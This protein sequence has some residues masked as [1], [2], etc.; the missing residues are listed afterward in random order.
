MAIYTYIGNGS[1]W[2]TPSAW[3]GNIVPTSSDTA[4]VNTAGSASDGIIPINTNVVVGTLILGVPSAGAYV[5]LRISY[6]C[7]LTVTGLLTTD[8]GSGT[9]QAAYNKRPVI[10]GPINSGYGINGSFTASLTV[11]AVSDTI[12][13]PGYINNIDFCGIAVYGNAAPLRG[14]TGAM[15]GDLKGNS[16]IIFPPARSIYWSGTGSIQGCYTGR[17]LTGT[18]TNCLPQDT[19]IIDNTT[20]AS[21][22]TLTYTNPRGNF[23]TETIGGLD[24]SL[25]TLP[26]TITSPNQG[27]LYLYG[28]LKLSSAV[29]IGANT[30][31]FS[32]VGRNTQTL[33]SA[34]KNFGSFSVSSPG[35]TVNLGDALNI[36]SSVSVYGGTFNTNNYNITASSFGTN[37]TTAL[38]SPI[39]NFGSSTINLSSSS[40]ISISGSI[41]LNAG[42][43]TVN[44][45]STGAIS[46]DFS[47]STWWNVNF[48]NTRTSLSL[49]GTPT[50]NN[51][52]FAQ[53]SLM[54]TITLYSNI[55]VTGT[56]TVTSVSAVTRT[57]F[58]SSTYG[59]RR[60]ITAAAV[61]LSDCDF[62]DITA[63]GTATWSGTRLG[64]CKGNSGITFTTPK[65]VYWNLL[66]ASLLWSATAWC[67]STDGGTTLS[68]PAVN[69]FPLAQDTA[70]FKE[71]GVD[72]GATIIYSTAWNLGSIDLSARSSILY[73]SFTV[74][75]NIYGDWTGYSILTFASAC[76]I[77][78]RGRNTQT[79]TTNGMTMSSMVIN[80]PGGIVQLGGYGYGSSVTGDAI[81]LVEGTFDSRTTY[82]ELYGGF[83][84]N[85]TNTRTLNMGSGNWTFRGIAP[86]YVATTNLTYNKGTSVI[87]LWNTDTSATT[88]FVG[89]D[90]SFNDIVIGGG[91]ATT[92][93]TFNFSGTSGYI[94]ALYASKNVAFTIAL[95][96]STPTYGKWLVTG[97]VGKVVTITGT[98]AI[99]LLER[100]YYSA[101]NYI[102]Y[103]NTTLATNSLVEFYVGPNSTGTST[104]ITKAA[105][106]SPSASR[107]L[108]WRGGTGTWNAS[109]TNWSLT[110]NG[111]GGQAPPT[112]I[113]D[114]I[115]DSTSNPT[116]YTVTIS[117]VTARCRT[118]SINGPVSGSVT[119][120]GT[121][122]LVVGDS[123]TLPGGTSKIIR[124]YTGT[125][126]LGN[127]YSD[128]I[129]TNSNISPN[130]VSFASP[131]VIYGNVNGTS[132]R[133]LQSALSTTST[134]TIYTGVLVTNGYGLTATS[135]IS[136]NYNPRGLTLNGS[137]VNLS[138]L[139]SALTLTNTNSLTF[140]AGTS[141]INLNLTQNASGGGFTVN[142]G[143]ISFYN[144]ML[145]S[146]ATAGIHNVILASDITISGTLSTSPITNDAIHR[147]CLLPSVSGTPRTVSVNSS[148]SLTD[149]DF[150]EITITGSAAP[151]TG[152][153]LGNYGGNSGITFTA[154][155][156]VYWNLS[157]TQ[158]WDATAWCT[159]TDGGTTLSAPDINNFPLA[160]DTAKFN[161][162]G[163]V[164]GTIS[165]PNS[166]SYAIGT[167]DCSNRTIAMTLYNNQSRFIYGSFILSSAVNWYS[168][169]SIYFA[170]R[171]SYTITSAG[172]PLTA[173]TIYISAI[174]G[175]Y[176]LGDAMSTIT[177][178]PMSVTNG[179]FTTNGYAITI[180]SFNSNA[181]TTRTINLGASTITCNN[182]FG[183]IWNTS[184]TTNLT[185]NAGT[186][187]IIF[188]DPTAQ[189]GYTRML[190]GGGLTYNKFT[191][192][193]TAA[194]NQIIEI[195]GNNTFNEITTTRTD[196]W[197][198]NFSSSTQTI[199]NWNITG[200]TGIVTVAGS[201]SLATL[202]LLNTVSNNIFSFYNHSL[203]NIKFV[204]SSP[205]IIS[206][207]NTITSHNNII[208]LTTNYLTTSKL[209]TSTGVL[210]NIGEF[211]EVTNN[212][213]AQGSILFNGSS[214]YLTLPTSSAFAYGTGDFTIEFWVYF[215][216]ISGYQQLIDTRPTGV[217]STVNYLA[218]TSIGGT[219]NYYTADNNP[220]ISGSIVV[221]A[222]QWYHIAITKLSGST[223]LF[224]N[225]VQSGS[226]YSDTTTYVSG[227]NRPIIGVDGNNP[228]TSFFNGYLSNLRIVKDTAVYTG[229]FTPP[230]Q[231]LTAIS[232]TSLLLNTR[233]SNDAFI[234][235]ST[236]ALTVTN[237][238]GSLSSPQHP[239]N[240]D[241]YYSYLFNGTTQ[242]LTVAHNTALSLTT[243]N[244][245]IEGWIRTN[246]FTNSPSIYY[247][248]ATRLIF[249]QIGIGITT[250]GRLALL[251]SNAAG[252]AWAIND[253][254][255]MP[256]ML[257]GTW[258]HFA[259]VRNGN[260]IQMYLDGTQYINSTAISSATT[261]RD[262]GS[263]V[264]IGAAAADGGGVSLP[265][266]GYISNF[267]VVKGT[268]VYTE[269]FTPPTS[270]LT[271]ITNTT[272]LTLQSNRIKDSNFTITPAVT[273]GPT[274]YSNT[275]P[276]STISYANTGLPV[277]KQ[278]STGILQTV[279]SFDEVS[280]NPTL[281]GSVLFNGTSQYM[282][283]PA[284]AVLNPGTGDFTIEAWI[285]LSAT[286]TNAS[287][288]RGNAN[289]IE[290]YIDGSNRLS[291]GYANNAQIC[292]DAVALSTGQWYHVAVAR[293]GT[294]LTLYKNGA[295]VATATNSTNY[296]TA[297]SNLIGYAGSSS[298]YFNGYISNL[299]MVKG[300]AVYT[301]AFTPPTQ[302]LTTT[303]PAGTNIAAITNQTSFL[304]RTLITDAS[305]IST[306]NLTITPVG[307]PTNSAANPFGTDIYGSMLFNGTTQYLTVPSNTV[308]NLTG[309]FT[310]EAWAYATTTTN[311][312][313]QLFNYGN[314][315]FML[316]H[317][318]TTWT[319][320]IGNGTS[321][322]FTLTGTASLNSWHH[323][324]ITRSGNIYTF[325]ID[326]VSALTA[327]NSNAPA[328]SGAALSIGR[329]QSAPNT[330]WFTGYISNFRI[331]KG[332]A[333]YTAA[334]TPPTAPLTAITNTSLLTCQSVLNQDNSTNVLA[335][336]LVLTN[337]GSTT[338]STNPFSRGYNSLSFDG[339]SQYLSF[340][341]NSSVQLSS[342]TWTIECWVNLKAFKPTI[343]ANGYIITSQTAGSNG[344]DFYLLGTTSAWNGIGFISRNG[345]TNTNSI[346]N[347]YSFA[348]NT[349]YHIAAVSA[350]NQITLYV[351]GVSV[352][353]NFFSGWT[354]TSTYAIGGGGVTPYEYY[355]PGYISNLRVVKGTAVYSSNFTPPK[356]P[357]T[358]ITNTS[359][360]ICQ[361]M[362]LQDNSINKFAITNNG[363]AVANQT[364]IPFQPSAI[365]PVVTSGT[366][367]R[368]QL[369]TGL[370]Q[371]YNQ[372]D[373]YTGIT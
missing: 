278:Y 266:D 362:V 118:L 250:A 152:T 200:N 336:K 83:N 299:R 349:W 231:P 108:Y 119:L 264:S 318:G 227:T 211:D 326:G 114:V 15:I 344:F 220:S 360:L 263:A 234:D 354:E 80:S 63:A 57:F 268:A 103:G 16:N 106:P 50:F 100:S 356:A 232:S 321:N 130:G 309:D 183:T 346:S 273:T 252:N 212:P 366:T 253:T 27:T 177:G 257:T 49:T 84:S 286:S 142:T 125:I 32:F 91:D 317:A 74:F 351:N 53:T 293:S 137:T 9:Y 165:I 367:L 342:S 172:I 365:D 176:T 327:T 64:D 11:N 170:G 181:T 249:A 13:G 275:L 78:F 4:I 282:T 182:Y 184:I 221:K 146:S 111:A 109:T 59:T 2:N 8:S 259:L 352:A 35:G 335:N 151:I 71:T 98:A 96:N 277:S 358:A 72:A 54:N 216:S 129:T 79:I 161:D 87:N 222:G 338:S 218:L 180:Y 345:V 207:D 88:T 300:L 33:T 224:I 245:T 141:T 159:S 95:G 135:L 307:T 154:P 308:L 126:I 36:T 256:V 206:K 228:T 198:L 25:R 226:T 297:T 134:I 166:T 233:Y 223:K 10:E 34:G 262:D 240:P 44:C 113:D 303:Q 323:F 270:P 285:Y 48:T 371:V 312:V 330:Q 291:V 122:T 58:I 219:I 14:P 370:I 62:R 46:A 138:G 289:G 47:T 31:I 279:G 239:F 147:I 271:A 26:I 22:A 215:N 202:I 328:T 355:L 40:P 339:T 30:F 6:G 164:T 186:S 149:I 97:S 123:M 280:L 105:V 334:F 329:S 187:N 1:S 324:A 315:I 67:T 167:L 136:S 283:V 229:A 92:G 124:T 276:F 357:L 43:S 76:T 284:N 160:Q 333:V 5:R 247:K 156:T 193:G 66:G 120:A 195:S 197:T 209:S 42:T 288:F 45:T 343:N 81:T 70:I 162:V 267:R 287:I 311:S 203:S 86:F 372:I 217:S 12:A 89:A 363:V 294:A 171:G 99:T 364:I 243:G 153:R 29:T 168:S 210:Y 361:S 188:A 199:T 368:K 112:S 104:T 175:T 73:L 56:L 85:Y 127:P 38:P 93:Q 189:V 75:A 350:N 102:A 225:G 140:D 348:L 205:L 319:V 320:E 260:N 51:L 237:T 39:V 369:N 178:G 41:T 55:I 61:S 192:G 306:N 258:Y 310:V 143:T 132:T 269:A 341:G 322:Y 133:T 314:F 316:Y 201:S 373:D 69:N 131:I 24:F 251:V 3:S 65:T 295:S 298:Y 238:A 121:A 274:I 116:A 18:I 340:T 68:S 337:N 332:T 148:S 290:L 196:A 115:F 19:I 331:V 241:G 117:T 110:Q 235:S 301:G 208:G 242:Y 158:N 139:G 90:L 107:T 169:Y 292:F 236:N 248:R 185:F 174:N 173:A 28:D 244:F 272:L 265:Y 281:N 77:Q 190:Y 214:Q 82:I 305:D 157:G 7:S 17:D 179:T 60:T 304:M 261:I 155:K 246:S 145:S 163:S 204:T 230:T 128:S 23:L 347:S 313:D 101:I 255:S 20:G 94:N 21:G 353:N 37:S 150:S 254:T 302:A 296:V 194:A 191:F 144:L 325:W 52:S 213:A 359:L